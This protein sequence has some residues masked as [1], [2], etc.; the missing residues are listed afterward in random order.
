MDG[1]LGSAA[2]EGGEAAEKEE[3]EGKGCEEM[4][5]V[6]VEIGIVKGWG[7]EMGVMGVEF[8]EGKGGL[9]YGGRKWGM[10]SWEIAS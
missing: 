6:D 8:G 3:V 5:V 7:W 4:H 2:D 9:M 10:D 1:S